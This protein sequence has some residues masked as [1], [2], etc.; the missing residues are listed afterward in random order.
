[1]ACFQHPVHIYGLK[2]R[3]RACA[4]FSLRFARTRICRTMLPAIRGENPSGG[5]WQREQFC[6]KTRSPS[7]ICTGC[8]LCFFCGVGACVCEF[9]GDCANTTKGAVRIPARTIHRSGFI[10]SSPS[11]LE[12]ENGRRYRSARCFCYLTLKTASNSWC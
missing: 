2:N 8:C 3:R 9:D 5:L 1:M 7:L 12:T 4:S 6:M 10:T 11:T